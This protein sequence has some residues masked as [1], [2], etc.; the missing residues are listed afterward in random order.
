MSE[1]GLCLTQNGDSEWEQG[2]DSI[3][4]G[5]GCGC[6]NGILLINQVSKYIK[7]N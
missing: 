1:R 5:E 4:E 6:I 3:C 2:E 7:Y